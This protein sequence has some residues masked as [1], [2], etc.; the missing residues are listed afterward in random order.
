MKIEGF[1]SNFKQANDIIEE[2]KK[3]GFD[4]AFADLNEHTVRDRNV[5][6]NLPRT[7]T[8]PSL[9]GLVLESD[10]HVVDRS[11]APLTAASPMVNGFGRFDEIADYN[12]KVVVEADN[13]KE[14]KVKDIIK[15]MDGE[16]ESPNV[17]IPKGIQD[18]NYL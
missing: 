3:N 8:S 5:Q 18:I 9:S 1:F 17:R 11:K 15:K 10:D 7:E 2:L 13:G 12:C 14:E 16:I 6:T 4:N